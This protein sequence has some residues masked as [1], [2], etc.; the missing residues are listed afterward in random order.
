MTT[1]TDKSSRAIA[2]FRELHERLPR[3]EEHLQY[4][5]PNVRE[6][7]YNQGVRDFAKAVTVFVNDALDE[8]TKDG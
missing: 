3:T 6:D 1:E 4:V 5:N 7:A 2:K 8:L